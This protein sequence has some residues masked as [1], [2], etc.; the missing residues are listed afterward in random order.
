MAAQ[1]NTTAGSAPY[2]TT[3]E[4][5]NELVVPLKSGGGAHNIRI[6]NRGNSDVL[7]VHLAKVQ[8]T[9]MA[10]KKQETTTGVPRFV[11]DLLLRD[12]VTEL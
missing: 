4:D 7:L 9:Y 6:L 10:F 2:T 11:R 12:W 5:R 8:A 1:D 3:G